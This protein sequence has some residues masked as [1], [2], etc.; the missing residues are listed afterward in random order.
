MDRYLILTAEYEAN[1]TDVQRSLSWL[2]P[3]LVQAGLTLSEEGEVRMWTGVLDGDTYAR[4][5]ERWGVDGER[6][7]YRRVFDGMEFE[8]EGSSPIIWARLD[9]SEVELDR[10]LV[11]CPH[12]GARAGLSTGICDKCGHVLAHPEMTGCARFRPRT[13]GRR[14]RRERHESSSRTRSPLR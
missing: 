11:C 9:V 7:S 2:A 8:H 14:V 12:C 3:E 4:F 13:I 10:P 1:A 6:P 5:A